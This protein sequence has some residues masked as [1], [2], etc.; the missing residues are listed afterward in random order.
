MPRAIPRAA[1]AHIDNLRAQA[2]GETN[3]VRYD[4]LRLAIQRVTFR[5]IRIPQPGV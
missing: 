2:R 4:R 3:P 5:Y 1:Q